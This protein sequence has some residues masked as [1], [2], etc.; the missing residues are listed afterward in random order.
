METSARSSQLLAEQLMHA[1]EASNRL[2]VAQRL[3]KN[4]NPALSVQDKAAYGLDSTTSDDQLRDEAINFLNLLVAQQHALHLLVEKFQATA[5]HKF[6]SAD[7]QP[8]AD[9]FG[10]RFIRHGAF[11]YLDAAGG[12][13]EALGLPSLFSS[14]TQEQR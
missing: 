3:I 9:N 12:L 2:I 8:L 10:Q 1:M 4:E 11:C 5:R 7:A 13:R 6:A 14:A